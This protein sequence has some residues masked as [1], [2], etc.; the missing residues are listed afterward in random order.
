VL[1]LGPPHS[2]GVSTL[3]GAEQSS[4]TSGNR[5]LEMAQRRGGNLAMRCQAATS[6]WWWRGPTLSS[7]HDDGARN[8]LWP[9]S[10]TACAAPYPSG[11][12]EHAVFWE[13]RNQTGLDRFGKWISKARWLATESFCLQNRHGAPGWQQR[14]GEGERIGRRQAGG[15]ASVWLL[16][17]STGLYPR[18]TA[19]RADSLDNA[20]VSGV[21]SVMQRARVSASRATSGTSYLGTVRRRW[22][23]TTAGGQRPQ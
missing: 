3:T 10:V 15:Q 4:G 17:R 9:G 1:A 11:W 12:D 14:V 20:R 22:G 16:V 23:T 7:L 2:A 13:D 18:Q 8:G 19:A 6:P 5:D 21:T